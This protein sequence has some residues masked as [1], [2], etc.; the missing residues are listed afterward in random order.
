MTY[1]LSL[2][3]Y[4]SSRC[5]LYLLHNLWAIWRQGSCHPAKPSDLYA[6]TLNKRLPMILATWKYEV[7]IRSVGFELFAGH[8][9]TAQY[10]SSIIC[11]SWSLCRVCTVQHEFPSLSLT[12]LKFSVALRSMLP[13]PR[14]FAH[15]THQSLETILE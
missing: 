1:A 6:F 14:R 9:G 10:G 5:H 12:S 4:G 7:G 2:M 3:Q 11:H 15:A 8:P 13:F